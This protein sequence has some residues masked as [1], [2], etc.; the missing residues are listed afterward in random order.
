MDYGRCLSVDNID[1]EDDDNEDE[2]RYDDDDGDKNASHHSGS[3]NKINLYDCNCFAELGS[4][5]TKII[6][7][8]AYLR[9]VCASAT[10]MEMAAKTTTPTIA[11]AQ[12]KGRR[13]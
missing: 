13:S 4:A 8:L 10:T 12:E 11:M 7:C 1:D 3:Y 9:F 6:S 5:G 2:V